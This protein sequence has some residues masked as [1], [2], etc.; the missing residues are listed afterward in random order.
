MY[1]DG[2]MS[3]CYSGSVYTIQGEHMESA[4]ADFDLSDFWKESEYATSAYVSPPPTD[5]LIASIEQELGYMSG[6]RTS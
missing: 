2:R 6:F 5:A 4:F 1:V 3:L